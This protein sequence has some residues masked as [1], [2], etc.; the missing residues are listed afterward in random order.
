MLL[1]KQAK[2]NKI[3]DT[4][5]KNSL[6]AFLPM[7]TLDILALRHILLMVY[8]VNATVYMDH[9]NDVATCK[10]AN[11]VV[12][13]I[14]SQRYRSN[15]LPAQDLA[16]RFWKS[17]GRWSLIFQ[18]HERHGSDLPHRPLETSWSIIRSKINTDTYWVIYV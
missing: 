5:I 13:L 17:S 9:C 12:A 8:I 7:H 2:T 4:L 1:R 18:I 6:Q 10:H 3:Y 15:L 16:H 14:S 11:I